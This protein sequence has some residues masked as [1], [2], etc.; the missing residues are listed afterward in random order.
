[1]KYEIYPI[2]DPKIREI[3]TKDSLII[4]RQECVRIFEHDSVY[5]AFCVSDANQHK[6]REL[7]ASAGDKRIGFTRI[8]VLFYGE[9]LFG[10]NEISNV[11]LQK[12]IEHCFYFS[13]EPINEAEIFG[14]DFILSEQN[15]YTRKNG[16][17]RVFFTRGGFA[18]YSEHDESV[19][20][21]NVFKVLLL[22]IY[23]I[24]YEKLKTN[25]AKIL[26]NKN[27]DEILKTRS[28]LLDFKVES[29]FSLREDIKETHEIYT[30]ANGYF[31]VDESLDRLLEL[32]KEHFDI[33]NELSKQKSQKRASMIQF[34]LFIITLCVSIDFI[35]NKLSLM[36]TN[37]MR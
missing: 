37:F 18:C 35:N 3:F 25:F 34:L 8:F 30:L 7:V 9:F 17:F 27:L 36:L 5:S 6:F 13:R 33:S 2:T 19:L 29:L 28:E 26:K 11:N 21:R 14:S 12:S 32:S 22:Q 20:S 15:N 10:V 24:V 16:K 1:M 23:F 4:E 31:R